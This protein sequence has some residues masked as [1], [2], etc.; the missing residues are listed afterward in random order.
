MV[1]GEMESFKKFLCY[2]EWRKKNPGFKTY[3]IGVAAAVGV[4]SML[5]FWLS[6]PRDNT[7]FSHHTKSLDDKEQRYALDTRE[8]QVVYTVFH[9]FDSVRDLVASFLAEDL[10]NI[11]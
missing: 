1:E 2:K 8:R 5:A 3:V 4:L 11:R 7:F 10:S 6:P 9:T